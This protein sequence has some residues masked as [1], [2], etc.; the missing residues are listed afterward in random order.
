[1]RDLCP[2]AQCV[3]DIITVWDSETFSQSELGCFV[4]DVVDERIG[5]FAGLHASLWK[6]GTNS[7][8][9]TTV[10]HRPV[11]LLSRSL[12]VNVSIYYCHVWS[13]DTN[14]RRWFLMLELINYINPLRPNSSNCYT[15]P[16]RRNLPF[17]VSDIQALW[18]SAL[19]ARVPEC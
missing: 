6:C 13:V 19:S 12:C 16:C 5:S 3:P 8:S 7:V 18:R 17:S 9:S 2:V 10:R 4:V 14:I 11:E 1:M 15:M